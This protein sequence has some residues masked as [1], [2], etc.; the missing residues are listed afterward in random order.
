MDGGTI[1]E[2]GTYDEL[3]AKSDIFAELIANQK[4]DIKENE[5]RCI[6]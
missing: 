1:A 5:R 4:L 3:I 6:T 2:S